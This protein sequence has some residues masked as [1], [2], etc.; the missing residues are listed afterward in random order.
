MGCREER[1]QARRT[2]GCLFEAR[3]HWGGPLEGMRGHW[4]G[5]VGYLPAANG[6]CG[7]EIVEHGVEKVRKEIGSE[8]CWPN[9][10]R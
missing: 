3:H 8:I 2:A 9:K 4:G 5:P 7:E 6:S 10:C 1:L